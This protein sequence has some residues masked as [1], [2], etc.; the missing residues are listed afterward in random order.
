[1]KIRG[2]DTPAI[3]LAV[4]AAGMTDYLTSNDRLIIEVYLAQARQQKF[5]NTI[6]T[7][8]QLLK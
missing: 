5:L 6:R 2:A 3:R 8:R 7:R 4:G 1:M